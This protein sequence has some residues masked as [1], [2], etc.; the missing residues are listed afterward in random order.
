MSLSAR[1]QRPDTAHAPVVGEERGAE[2]IRLIMSGAY[3]DQELAAE[4]GLLPPALLPVGNQ[5]LYEHQIAEFGIGSPVHL[6]LPESYEPPPEDQRR[7][8]ELGVGVL[9]VPDDLRLGEAIVYALNYLGLSNRPVRILLGDTLIREMPGDELDIMAIGTDDSGYSWAYVDIEAGHVRGLRTTAGSRVGKSGVPVVCGL[10]VFAC[11]T[12]LIRALIRARGDFIQGLNLYAAERPVRAVQAPL[13]FDFGHVQTFYR[14]RL[15]MT[16]QRH[17]NRLR[18]DGRTVRKSSEDR[19]KIRA[20]AA[21]FKELP[22]QIQV[23]SARLLDIGEEDDLSH[24]DTEYE[25]LPTLAELFVF[26][27]L[28][29]P[30]WDHIIRCCHDFLAACASV[31]GPG[32]AADALREL[33]GDKTLARLERFR[34]KT[35][36]DI[37]R[38]ISFEGRALPSLRQIGERTAEIATQGPARMEAV[39]H[40]DFCFS[41]ILY[42]SRTGRIRVIDPRGYVF[43]GR[44]SIFGDLRYDYAK[45]SHSI[46]GRYDE[47]LAGR[48]TF[49]AAGHSFAIAFSA[50]PQQAWVEAAMGEMEVDGVRANSR[51][52][53]AIMTALFL[54]M[55]PL[56]EDRPDRQ[57]A[58]IANAARLYAALET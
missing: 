33:A 5:R 28:G 26:G 50:T 1:P 39:M 4:F 15:A 40:G 37:D 7:L 49:D 25:Y 36:F 8:G 53:Y 20:E 14:S 30:S 45:L 46:V 34:A 47:I 3:I 12:A 24:Y 18:I 55:L 58:F 48:Y 23:Y 54:S 44:N 51:E 27:S 6:T 13:W 21:W 10:F 42:N 16:T 41:N 43:G 38:E 22:S 2:D 56:H 29:R 52:V 11:A 57:R 9:P 32:T 17:F 31:R 19:D 35:G